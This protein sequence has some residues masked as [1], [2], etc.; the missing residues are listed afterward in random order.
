MREAHFALSNCRRD[1]KWN[2]S[3][4]F[5]IANMCAALAE[6][7]LRSYA[8]DLLHFLRWWA[9]VNHTDAI[10]EGA[11][12]T[13]SLLDY[14]RFQAGQHPR[15]TAPTINHRV[16]VVERALHSEFPDAGTAFKPGFHH[17]YWRRSPLGFNRPRPA[18]RRGQPAA[19]A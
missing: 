15:P 6:A 16:G 1:G 5:W 11:L 10:H 3:I 13:T 7:T 17:L 12:S 2:G 19:R 9:H 14:L 8:M 18:L 4:A